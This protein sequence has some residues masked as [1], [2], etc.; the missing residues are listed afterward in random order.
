MINEEIVE[1]L[2]KRLRHARQRSLGL[3]FTMDDNLT[4]FGGWE[5]G[6]WSACVSTLENALDEIYGDDSWENELND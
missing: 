1:Y 6:Y 5:I 3:K 2:K 4:K